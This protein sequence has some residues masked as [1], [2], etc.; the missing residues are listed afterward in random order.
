M[1][2]IAIDIALL[3]S[4]RINNICLKI[5]RSAGAE[6]FS[7]LSKENNYPHITLAMGAM[8][9][10]DLAAIENKVKK[11]SQK[12]RALDLEIIHLGNETTPENKKSSHLTIKPNKKLRELHGM[13]MSEL[14]PI[15]SYEIKKEM[16]FIDADE[17][18]KKVSKYWVENYGKKHANPQNYHP[19]ISLKCRNAKYNNL[20]LKFTASKLAICQLGNYCTCRKIIKSI[21]LQTSPSA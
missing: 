1:K 2:K 14:L 5:N 3:L 17:N 9:E 10:G 6:A 21:N 4:Q 20:P 8:D 7:D 11:I 18:F 16:F 13:I 19:H 15:F 12:F